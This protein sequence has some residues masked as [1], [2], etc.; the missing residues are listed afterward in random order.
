MI[1]Q[2]HALLVGNLRVLHETVDSGQHCLQI[3]DVVCLGL[4]KQEA[5]DAPSD[6]LVAYILL[7]GNYALVEAKLFALAVVAAKE[8][9]GS[10]SGSVAV[11]AS[12]SWCCSLW[13][14]KQ[15]V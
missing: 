5:L 13:D 8:D 3:Q 4:A 11:G 7:G 14:K 1:H 9:V 2:Q 6:W 15:V 10:L 12:F